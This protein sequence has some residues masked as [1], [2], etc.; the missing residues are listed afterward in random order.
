MHVLT[1]PLPGKLITMEEMS[2]QFSSY[3]P[4]S[5]DDM[6]AQEGIRNTGSP[7]GDRKKDQRESRERQVGPSGMAE[8]RGSVSGSRC[9]SPGRLGDSGRPLTYANLSDR[10]SLITANH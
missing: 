3:L 1:G 7:S 5:D 2:E 10:E 6:H 9:T 4:G 8:R